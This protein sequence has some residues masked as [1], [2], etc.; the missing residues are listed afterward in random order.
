MDASA[1]RPPHVVADDED[2][3][4]ETWPC[5]RHPDRETALRCVECDRP[6]CVDCAVQGAVGFKCPDDARIGRAAR[7]VIPR[8]RLV[9]G[10]TVAIVA[11]VVLGA[12]FASV[13][14]PF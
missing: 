6:I 12:L 11:A 4:H 7:A 13:R 3:D 10:A 1:P 5:Y 14:V 9:A 2:D 8:T